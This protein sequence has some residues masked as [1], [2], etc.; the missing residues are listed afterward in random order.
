MKKL[1]A[2]IVL[3]LL[4]SGN[5]KAD[6]FYM[7]GASPRTLVDMGFKLFS[8]E[9]LIDSNQV[10]YTFIKEDKIVSCRVLLESPQYSDNTFGKKD[11]RLLY[12]TKCFY[13][14]NLN[15]DSLN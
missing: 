7:D 14:T 10:I 11:H 12:P 4:W 9:P 13:I 2:I 1:L 6:N 3:G 8:V 15:Q 5:V